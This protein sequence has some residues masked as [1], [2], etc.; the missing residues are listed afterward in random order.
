MADRDTQDRIIAPID[1][2]VARLMEQNIR[3]VES[4]VGTQP[5]QQADRRT[6]AAITSDPLQELQDLVIKIK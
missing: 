6:E 1:I 3:L 4:I 5:R 2:A